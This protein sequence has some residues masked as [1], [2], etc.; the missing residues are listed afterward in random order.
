MPKIPSSLL[1]I[2]ANGGLRLGVVLQSTGNTISYDIVHFDGLFHI[3]ENL[4]RLNKNWSV[5]YKEYF[6][7]KRMVRH[8]SLVVFTALGAKQPYNDVSSF[9]I[10]GSCFYGSITKFGFNVC[11]DGRNGKLFSYCIGILECR[12]LPVWPHK[13]CKGIFRLEKDFMKKYKMILESLE[14]TDEVPCF[15]CRCRANYKRENYADVKKDVLTV[16]NILEKK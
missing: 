1:D 6:R 15:F 9:E 13:V 8:G 14:F 4:L 11:V 7:V 2:Y 12:S 10:V 16:Y 3:A 5:A